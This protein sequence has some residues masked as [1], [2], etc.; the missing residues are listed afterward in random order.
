MTAASAIRQL[1]ALLLLALP[2]ASQV[3]TNY[4]SRPIFNL[5]SAVHGLAALLPLQPIL[6]WEIKNTGPPYDIVASNSLNMTRVNV[7]SNNS[8]PH[9][10]V[11]WAYRLNNTG[12]GMYRFSFGLNVTQ[13]GGGTNVP[14]YILHH[15]MMNH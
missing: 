11:D 15:N 12:G 1:V 6:S 3:L 5:L 14:S 4:T 10:I 7:T 9:Y 8:N 13:C 2:I